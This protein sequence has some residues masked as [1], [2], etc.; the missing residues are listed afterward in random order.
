MCRRKER[1]QISPLGYIHLSRNVVPQPVIHSI[2][3]EVGGVKGLEVPLKV[4]IKKTAVE[5]GLP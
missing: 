1:D 5:K 3:L 4:P 2:A